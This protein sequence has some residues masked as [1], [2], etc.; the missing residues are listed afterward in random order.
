MTSLPEYLISRTSAPATHPVTLG[1]AKL[2]CRIDH[3]TDD[4]L[5]TRLIETASEVVQEMT[6]KA[7]ITQSWAL[8]IRTPGTYV[9]LPVFPAISLTSVEYI[10][11]DGA[12]QTATL[13]NFSLYGDEDSAWVEPIEGAV[14]P[15]TAD[16]LD[17]LTLTFVAGFGTASNVPSNL[18]HAILMTISH[19]YE[20]RETVADSGLSELPYAATHLIG[21]SKKGWIA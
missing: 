12:D 15:T 5:I 8:K 1:E 18:K 3:S 20:Q 16:R 21:L 6:G 7:L 17:A 13:G 19:W 10:D 11:P 9:S 4:I 2:Q 14:W